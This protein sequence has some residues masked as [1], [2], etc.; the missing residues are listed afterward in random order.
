MMLEHD[1]TGEAWQDISALTEDFTTPAD[2]CA[3]Y[4]EMNRE[5][6]QFFEDLKEHISLENNLIFLAS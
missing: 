5:L 4:Q 2:G 1:T 6:Y 3:S